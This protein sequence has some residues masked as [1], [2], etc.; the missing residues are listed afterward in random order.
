MGLTPALVRISPNTTQGWR[1]VSVKIQPNELASTGSSG[2]TPAAS[3]TQREVGARPR[4]T[5]HQTSSAN[6]AAARPIPIIRRN[7][8]NATGMLGR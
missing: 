1:P 5:S 6:A 2:T 3:R 8:Q 7:D 4:R